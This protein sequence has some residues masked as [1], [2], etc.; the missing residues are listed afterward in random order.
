MDR[1]SF[2]DKK[3]DELKR[4]DLEQLTACFQALEHY[5]YINGYRLVLEPMKGDEYDYGRP[6]DEQ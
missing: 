6:A 2:T 4:G 5:Y 3:C 1:F